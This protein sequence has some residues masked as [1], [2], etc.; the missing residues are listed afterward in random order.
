P[1]PSWRGVYEAINENIKCPQRRGSSIV[2]GQEDCLVLNVFNPL[3]VSEADLLPVMFFIH[4]GGFYDGSSTP[5]IYG[6]GYLVNKGIILVTINYR[7]NVQGF[8]CL[9]MKEAPGN[10][11]MKDQVA[12]LK[13]VRKNIKA[14]GGD[15]DNVTIFGESAGGASVS[16]HIISPM[17]EGLFHKA[18]IQSGS[19]LA[20]WAL[21]F[22]PVYMAS[23]L[24]KV[25]LYVTEDPYEI[26][27]TLMN[28]SDAELV[29]TRVPRTEGNVIISEL[30]YVPCVEHEIDGEESFLTDQPYN[31][32]SKGE[33]NKVPI[34]LGTCNEEGL[35]FAALENDTVLPKIAVEKTLPKNLY[36]PT[37]E[38]KKEVA[39]KL[40]NL[41]FGDKAISHE[42]LA[43]LSRMHGE[44]YITHP[45]LEE[46]E[47]YLDTNDKPVYSYVFSYY[48]WRN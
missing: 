6:P 36:I 2:V 41:Y 27:E 7:L 48:G 34:M 31:T 20:P 3:D 23:L 40:H 12:A 28:K 24:T 37:E 38:E 33:Y 29:I 25:M 10:A 15:P 19:S 42:T 4:G 46:T 32:L 21:Q 45:T 9:R 5:L 8:A 47:L 17:S 30:L 11:G 16:Y 43:N 13:W 39:Q 35:L 44:V 1:A 14:F 18:I 26:Y 22:K